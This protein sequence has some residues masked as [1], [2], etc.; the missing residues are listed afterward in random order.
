MTAREL[1]HETHLLLAARGALD[2]DGA[3]REQRLMDLR[4]LS[5]IELSPAAGPAWHLLRGA[6]VAYVRVADRD[7]LAAEIAAMLRRACDLAQRQ[8]IPERVTYTGGALLH[9]ERPDA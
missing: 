1:P 7:P 2:V 8:G 5:Y 6:A 4:Q 3:R 9:F